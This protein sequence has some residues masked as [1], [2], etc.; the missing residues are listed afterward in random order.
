MCTLPWN[1]YSLDFRHCGAALDKGLQWLPRG[2]LTRSPEKA[3][4]SAH[5]KASKTIWN[6][7]QRCGSLQVVQEARNS[8]Q[9]LEIQQLLE[10]HYSHPGQVGLWVLAVQGGP[11][12]REKKRSSQ[13]QDSRLIQQVPQWEEPRMLPNS[14]SLSTPFASLPLLPSL[15]IILRCRE[16]MTA[17]CFPCPK[18]WCCTSRNQRDQA[19]RDGLQRV[20]WLYLPL[21]ERCTKM[22]LSCLAA[23]L[24]S[25]G[26]HARPWDSSQWTETWAAWPGSLY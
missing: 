5:L 1:R 26:N 10:F 20:L 25:T 24:L 18:D 15:F 17:Q 23:E 11:D 4:E 9:G 8:H 16:Q 14:G 6:N 22:G 19:W 2:Y 7:V 3:E 21:V 12:E 13:A